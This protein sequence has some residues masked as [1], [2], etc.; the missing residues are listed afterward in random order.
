V[1]TFSVIPIG[2]V[3]LL[4]Y[5]F[6]TGLF[7]S[8]PENFSFGVLYLV[9]FAI[10][11]GALPDFLFYLGVGRLM[12]IQAG[13]ILLVEPISAAILSSL[14]KISYLSWLQIVGGALILLSNYFVLL[15]SRSVAPTPRGTQKEDNPKFL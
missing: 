7:L 14:F 10:S 4:A 5:V 12:A 11:A 3:S 13:V 1:R 9:L 2:I 8:S 6:R 15:E